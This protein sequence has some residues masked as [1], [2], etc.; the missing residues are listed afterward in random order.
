MCAL[1]TKVFFITIF[2]EIKHFVNCGRKKNF[3]GFILLTY[4]CNE[5]CCNPLVS[6]I[7]FMYIQH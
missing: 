3:F 6:P 4:S 5:G 7:S 1:N 2:L